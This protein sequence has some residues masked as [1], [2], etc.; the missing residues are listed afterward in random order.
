[1]V[2]A[3]DPGKEEKDD[4]YAFFYLD[5]KE[6][7]IKEAVYYLEGIP[8]VKAENSYKNYGKYY[9]PYKIVLTSLNENT[10]DVFLFKDYRFNK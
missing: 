1:M 6:W 7:V 8:F 9:M 2:K 3:W 5:N 10:S 4:N